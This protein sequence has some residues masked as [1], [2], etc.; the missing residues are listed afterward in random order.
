V[1]RLAVTFLF[2]F[3]IVLLI[4]PLRA[5]AAAPQSCTIQ[6]MAPFLDFPLYDA[7]LLTP[8]DLQAQLRV[9][10]TYADNITITLGP[11]PNSGGFSPRQMKKVDL[12]NYNLYRDAAMTEI[13]G[14]GTG[15]TLA[16]TYL[17]PGGNAWV[18]SDIYG[19]IP[20]GQNVMTSGPGASGHTDNP[21]VATVSWSGGSDTDGV[22]M[23]AEVI[24]TCAFS[25]GAGALAFGIYDPTDPVAKT[26]ST[27][28][29]FSCNIGASYNITDDE[30]ANELVANTPPHRMISGGN[31]LPYTITYDDGDGGYVTD[32]ETGA[33]AGVGTPITLT[34][35]GVIAPFNPAPMGSYSDT[36]IFTIT[37]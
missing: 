18:Y 15:G 6:Y 25:S 3:A 7:L 29:S 11:S 2:F 28:L 19:R 26:A 10:C 16:V 35:D 17:H 24:A 23:R 30:G 22:G 36:I 33:G 20:P 32:G 34:I 14:D 4:M 9:K 13:W 37:F 5:F 12:L 21:I 1:K 8:T 27:S 31:F